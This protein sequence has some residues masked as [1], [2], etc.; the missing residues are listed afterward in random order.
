MEENTTDV[1]VEQPRREFKMWIVY[2]V[3]LLV[4]FLFMFFY[5][6]N[7][8]IH[9]FNS[10]C[11]YQWYLTMGR[12]WMAGKIPY[13]DLFEQKGPIIYA[14]FAIASLFP[15]TQ[16]AVWCVEVVV[17]S[18][19]L[20]F[21]YRIAR[22]FLS[23]WLSLLVLP[24]MMMILSTNYC[25]GL[26]GACVEE[27]CLPIF[28]YGLLCFLDFIMDKR[29][30]TWQRSL[31]LG[32][33]IG[34]LFWVKFTMLEFFVVPLLIWV[35]INLRQLK[36]VMRSVLVMLGGL[37]IVTVPIM[38]YFTAVGAL[39]D[40]FKVYFWNNLSHYNGDYL[41]GSGV[42]I[43]N[44]WQNFVI[45]WQIGVFYIMALVWGV[46]N[47]AIRNWKQKSGWLLLIAVLSTWLMVGFFC[48]YFY[49]YLP[50]F[51]YAILGAIY[52]VDI[53]AY[54]LT[55]WRV[56]IRRHLIKSVI[57]SCVIVLSLLA[58]VP[59]VTNT[60]E[61]CREREKY[62]P[63]VVA[64]MIAE[65]NKTSTHPATLFC[66]RMVDCGFYNAANLIPDEY[67]YAQNCFTKEGFPEMFESFDNTIREQKCDF[68]ITYRHTYN[69]Q[70]AFLET[71]YHPYIE[72]DLKKSTLPFSFFEPKYYGK[73]EI[74]VLFRN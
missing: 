28:A 24:L 34:I 10:H 32:I 5:G 39:D 26:E 68:V 18:L 7:S 59:F 19:F 11:D 8:P 50:L 71:Y 69:T 23:P 27:Y 41:T 29:P 6:L 67:Y 36:T 12:G 54:M 3:C 61:I 42:S 13:R 4:S 14:V 53:V 65:Y 21:C 33:C 17:V 31:A 44:P 74:V 46:I 45:S 73:N 63:L 16:F 40:L 30:T 15:N 1:N 37:L 72:N 9:T 43:S 70:R 62:A 56:V 20:F 57:V 60:A 66:Y 35:I 2:V 52:V 49:Y 22:K 58:A 51:V 47:F 48:G 38:I 25:R 64:D 55:S